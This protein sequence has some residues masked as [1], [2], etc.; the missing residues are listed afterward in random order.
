MSF[1]DIKGQDRAVTF[2]KS[3]IENNR[4][5]HAYIFLGPS[6][7]GKALTAL[8]FAKALNCQSASGDRPCDECISCR[9]IDNLNHPDLFLLKPDKKGSSIGIDDIRALIKDITL[10]PYEARKKVYIIDG[11]DHMTQQASNALLKTLEE[12]QGDAILVLVAENLRALLPTIQSR[13]QVVRFFP[14]APDEAKSILIETYKIDD[15]RAHILS[16][17]SAGRIGEAVR[18]NDE[19]VFEERSGVIARLIDDT[20][21]DS[22]FN[23]VSREDFKVDLDIML[24]WYR[25][26][27]MAKAGSANAETLVNVD[28][29][30][31]ILKESLRKSFKYL[32]NAIRQIIA[33]TYFL[34]ENANPKLAMGVLGANINEV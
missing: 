15:T 10:K 24:T 13:V 5:S 30:D 23:G 16:R 6:G 20:F 25:D 8:N 12:P 4:L 27:L 1:K 34:E 33:T 31:E 3:S 7:I 22:D 14:L 17:L 2:L 26:I 11:A 28:K 32:D 9:K 29:S 19:G 21:F 18:Y